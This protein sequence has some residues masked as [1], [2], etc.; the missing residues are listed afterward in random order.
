MPSDSRLLPFRS[1]VP[2]LANY[3]FE[4]IDAGFAERCKNAGACAIIGGD[5]YGQGSSREHAALAPLHLG[6]KFVIAKSFA[7]IHRSNLINSGI[8]PLV[9][10]D[11]A[12]YDNISLGDKLVI[13]NAVSQA[14][15][16]HINVKNETT[17]KTYK[18][19][20]DFRSLK[21]L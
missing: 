13:E 15:A 20:A 18:T 6:V 14:G 21:R 11:P 10:D 3:C 16:K 1:N 12:D 5:N 4:K 2:H 7:R 19:H 9:F 17:G 8:M